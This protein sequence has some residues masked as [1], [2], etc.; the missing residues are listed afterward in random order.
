MQTDDN[1]FAR[2][3]SDYISQEFLDRYDIF[4]PIEDLEK[5]IKEFMENL[6]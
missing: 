2:Y 1:E 3:L 5:V 6:P 4:L